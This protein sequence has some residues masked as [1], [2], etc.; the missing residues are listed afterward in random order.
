MD[1]KSFAKIFL[2]IICIQ[3][4]KRNLHI[5]SFLNYTIGYLN[6][7]K[8]FCRLEVAWS[9]SKVY[10]LSFFEHFFCKH[11]IKKLDFAK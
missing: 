6:F 10:I 11:F 7:C 4:V 3:P 8:K 1:F 5:F 9:F 2:Q